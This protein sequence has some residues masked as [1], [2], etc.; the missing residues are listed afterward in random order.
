MSPGREARPLSAEEFEKL[1]DAG[2]VSFGL[3]LPASVQSGLAGYLS[4]LDRWRR[5]TNL[6]G[7]LSGGKLARHVLESVLA[8]QLIA[9]GEKLIDIGS[10]AGFPGLALAIARPD[11]SVTLVEPRQKRAAFLRH[12]A[13]VLPVRNVKVREA[14]IEEVGGQTF[15]VATTRAV[16]NFGD[17]LGDASFLDRNGLLLVWTNEAARP[18]EALSGRLALEHSVAIPDSARAEIAVFRKTRD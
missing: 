6:T 11:L 4:E 1:L 17:W 13:R 2:Q 16:G 12:V 3:T 8:S 9:H 14:R 5:T 18:V 7:D 15:G 10:G